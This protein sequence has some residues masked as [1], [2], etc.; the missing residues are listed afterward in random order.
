MINVDLLGAL[1]GVCT[2]IAFAPQA[3]RVWK[4]RS[5]GDIS[6]TM[7]VLFCTGLIMWV[8]YGLQL[9]AWPIILT[10]AITLLLAGSVLAMK[11]MFEAPTVNANA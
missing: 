4:T 7:Y 6:L 10:I 8:L 11:I 3:F 9:Q 1:A 5:V 2:T